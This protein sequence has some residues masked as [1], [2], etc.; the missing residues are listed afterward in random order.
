MWILFFFFFLFF[1]SSKGTNNSKEANANIQWKKRQRPNVHTHTKVGSIETEQVFFL[2]LVTVLA[3]VRYWDSIAEI[4]TEKKLQICNRAYDGRGTNTKQKRKEN[5]ADACYSC[6]LITIN[7]FNIEMIKLQWVLSRA[8]VLYN[9]LL[10]KI[11]HFGPFNA[12]FILVTV[13]EKAS[14][15]PKSNSTIF[16]FRCILSWFFFLTLTLK[17]VR[18]KLD[19]FVVRFLVV[20][21]HLQSIDFL[22]NFEFTLA[23]AASVFR[24]KFNR[25]HSVHVH[26]VTNLFACWVGYRKM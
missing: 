18:Y 17:C 4:K 11:R 19:A 25:L 6:H 2:F 3:N 8:N 1:H 14:V 13:P 10:M 26:A 20:V 12:N 16:F 24:N 5:N 7:S 23:A 21:V 9:K 22:I 15:F